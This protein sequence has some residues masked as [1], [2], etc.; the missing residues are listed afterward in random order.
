MQSYTDYTAQLY[1][2]TDP[3]MVYLPT[4]PIEINHS[5]IGE[6][7]SPM[8]GLGMG[9]LINHEIRIPINQPV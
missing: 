1:P 3:C 4:F 7:T 5:C 2:I 8:D 6:Y 9:I